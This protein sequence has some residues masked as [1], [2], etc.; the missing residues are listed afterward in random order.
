MGRK[1]WPFERW[2]FVVYRYRWAAFPVWAG[3]AVA[4]A[5]GY[6]WFWPPFLVSLLVIV[7]SLDVIRRSS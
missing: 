4:L 7:A 3:S 5:F 2:P 1:R 6:L